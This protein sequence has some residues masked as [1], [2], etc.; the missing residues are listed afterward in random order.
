M[1]EQNSKNHT[2]NKVGISHLM[3]DKGF[4]LP[5]GKGIHG[6]GGI[7]GRRRLCF[8]GDGESFFTAGLWWLPSRCSRWWL[9]SELWWWRREWQLPPW[10]MSPC[11]SCT[12]AVATDDTSFGG[13]LRVDEDGGRDMA[14]DEERPTRGR[15]GWRGGEQRRIRGKG[16][17]KC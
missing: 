5:G 1:S 10:A 8:V 15:A 16:K 7:S 13:V 14:E 6:D 17:G 2:Q 11:T 12:L 3:I 4:S 9:P